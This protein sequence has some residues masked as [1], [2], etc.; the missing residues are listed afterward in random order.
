MK[1]LDKNGNRYDSLLSAYIADI[2]NIFAE[3]KS[4]TE[5]KINIS[6]NYNTMDKIEYS[7]D[8]NEQDNITDDAAEPVIST[9]MLDTSLE[10]I[11]INNDLHADT[12][13]KLDKLVKDLNV[14]EIKSVSNSINTDIK[15][16]I[17]PSGF[18]IKVL[19]KMNNYITENKDEIE[20]DLR[21]SITDVFT[22]ATDKFKK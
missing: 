6:R 2:K 8:D 13:D 1:Y 15:P 20:T 22:K 11:N 18:V 5:S 10:T 16:A 9:G 7:C 12:Y 21:T 3:K 14:M 4:K 19:D 17:N